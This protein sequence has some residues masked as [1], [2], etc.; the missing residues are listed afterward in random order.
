AVIGPSRGHA[1]DVAMTEQLE[2]AEGAQAHHRQPPAQLATE[3][4]HLV[5]DHTLTRAVELTAVV[6]PM[7]LQLEPEPGGRIAVQH[8]TI[9]EH[10][11][12]PRGVEP[13]PVEEHLATAGLVLF[14]PLDA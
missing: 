12:A 13:L 4:Q 9:V 8:E 6:Q 11:A 1:V 7:T 10:L 3:S 5:I 14:A 2:C